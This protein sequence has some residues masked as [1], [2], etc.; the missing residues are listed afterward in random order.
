MLHSKYEH[1]LC[2]VGTATLTVRDTG[3]GFKLQTESKRHGL[4]WCGG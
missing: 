1:E 2:D 3:A 4:V